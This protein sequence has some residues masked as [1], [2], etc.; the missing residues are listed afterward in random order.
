MSEEVRLHTSLGSLS[1]DWNGTS[2]VTW[3]HAEPPTISSAT[4]LLCLEST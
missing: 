1:K 3:T 2:H 4:P